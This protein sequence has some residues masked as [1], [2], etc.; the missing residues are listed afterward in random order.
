LYFWFINKLNK[1]KEYSL[2]SSI[3][4]LCFESFFL[5]DE[6][7]ASVDDFFWKNGIHTGI[8]ETITN[9]QIRIFSI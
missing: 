5:K 2:I 4:K 1:K 7:L 8:L 3:G 6:C 9:F